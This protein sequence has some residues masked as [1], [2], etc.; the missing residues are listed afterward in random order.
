MRTHLKNILAKFRPDPNWNDG[1]LGFLEEVTPNTKKK[2][3]KQ[4]S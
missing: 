4:D 3:N 2:N 1:A